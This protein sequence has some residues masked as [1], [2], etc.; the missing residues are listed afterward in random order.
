MRLH[1]WSKIP[2]ELGDR[3][4]VRHTP[5]HTHFRTTYDEL[6]Q[7]GTYVAEHLNDGKGPR[8][9]VVPRRG[10]SMMNREDMPLFDADANKGFPDALH[11]K[12][13]EDVIL[14]ERDMHINDEEFASEV[15]DLFMQLWKNKLKEKKGSYAQS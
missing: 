2:D 8:A 14:F 6:Y 12:L 9:V 4:Y 5:T 1:D 7:V 11:D 10:Y 13:N 15:V 3:P